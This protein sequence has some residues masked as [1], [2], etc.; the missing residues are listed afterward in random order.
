GIIQMHRSAHAAWDEC[1]RFSGENRF[2]PGFPSSSDLASFLRIMAAGS[3]PRMNEELNMAT[4][5][6]LK[7]GKWRAQV[8]KYGIYRSATFSRNTEA[9]A[10][11][12]EVERQLMYVAVMGCSQP[13]KN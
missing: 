2:F 7:S 6:K 13:P 4:F 9:K 8:R 11:A 10:W 3:Q 1:W 12:A 5:T